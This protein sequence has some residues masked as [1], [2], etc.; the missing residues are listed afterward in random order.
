MYPVNFME[1]NFAKLFNQ[2]GTVY[3][4]NRDIQHILY[5]LF[6]NSSSV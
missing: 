1:F 4:D 6:F 3:R 5:V 2:L